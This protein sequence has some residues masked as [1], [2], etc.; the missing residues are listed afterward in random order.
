MKLLGSLSAVLTLVGCA[1]AP[2]APVVAAP[3][4][5]ASASVPAAPAAPPVEAKDEAPPEPAALP[6]ECAEEGAKPCLPEAEF[7]KRLCA[8]VYP[9]VALTMFGKTQPWTRAYLTGD[10]EAWNASGG[11]A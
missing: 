6:T 10:T 2:Q 8:G 1:S 9:E 3:P 4:A 7:A 5:L 11:K